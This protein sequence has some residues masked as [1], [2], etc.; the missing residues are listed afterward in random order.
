MAG[1]G[2]G[3]VAYRE[4]VEAERRVFHSA[5]LVTDTA[6]HPKEFRYTAPLAISPLQQALYGDTLTAAFVG[7]VLLHPLMEA[8]AERPEVWLVRQPELVEVQ[9]QEPLLGVPE[10]PEARLTTH[11]DRPDDLLVVPDLFEILA[12]LKPQKV[13]ERIDGAFV[14]LEKLGFE[15]AAYEAPEPE[16][17]VLAVEAPE[18][19]PQPEVVPELQPPVEDAGWMREPD[20]DLSISDSGGF[21]FVAPSDVAAP[22]PRSRKTVTQYTLEEQMH[23]LDQVLAWL[24]RSEQLQPSYLGYVV[25]GHLMWLHRSHFLKLA[26]P[27]SAALE[28]EVEVDRELLRRTA[29][30]GGI[31]AFEVYKELYG[32]M[33]VAFKIDLRKFPEAQAALQTLS[34]AWR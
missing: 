18:P 17:E 28:L 33:A 21:H 24:M 14:E 19:E 20:I 13:F 1:R 26:E 11:P 22:Q 9:P 3:F 31:E 15:A 34:P 10:D 8:V 2:I 16:P 12:Q 25:S 29:Q 30:A 5:V 7:K 23:A 6:G 32:K 4:V 27:V